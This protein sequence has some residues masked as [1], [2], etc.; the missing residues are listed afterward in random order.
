MSVPDVVIRQAAGD[1]DIEHIRELLRE[2][3]NQLDVDLC[4]QDFDAELATL[5]GR[6]AQPRGS[7]LI[8]MSEDKAAGCIALRPVDDTT[9][10]MKRLFVGAAFRGIGL[11]RRLVMAILGEARG[12]N[13]NKIR[14]DTLPQQVE[15]H[16]LYESLGFRDVPPYSDFPIAGSRFLELELR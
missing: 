3:A 12:R 9:C 14:L 8:A 2:Y 13:Y 5:P 4:F 11:G 1:A 16:R 10:E 7:L 6:Y 15:A